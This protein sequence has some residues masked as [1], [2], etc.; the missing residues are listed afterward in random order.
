MWRV[1]PLSHR[2]ESKKSRAFVSDIFMLYLN[3]SVDVYGNN[4]T[5]EQQHGGE[6]IDLSF[7]MQQNSFGWIDTTH[8]VAI[9]KILLNQQN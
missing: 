4:A 8:F 5:Q 7:Q 9:S 6:S 1:L 2:N 3:L